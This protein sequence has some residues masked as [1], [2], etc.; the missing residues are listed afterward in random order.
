MSALQR[1]K[2]LGLAGLA[3]VSFALPAVVKRAI[4][5]RQRRLPENAVRCALDAIRA[6]RRDDARRFVEKA[7]S[8]RPTDAPVTPSTLV[9]A[10]TELAEALRRAGLRA[11]ARAAAWKA[12]RFHHQT[13][14]PAEDLA[15]W[16]VLAEDWST[17]DASRF[18]GVLS[19]VSACSDAAARRVAGLVRAE[20]LAAWGRDLEPTAHRARRGRPSFAFENARPVDA[21]LGP[22]P[23]RRVGQNAVVLVGSGAAEMSFSLA[24]DVERLELVAGAD[25][26]FG[27]GA[28]ALVT[29]D[30]GEPF[31]LYVSGTSLVEHPFPVSLSAGAHRIR[32]EYLNDARSGAQDRN[33]FL[34]VLFAGS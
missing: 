2:A 1:S 12:V 33:L 8:F 6:G 28:I 32:V 7:L 34:Y 3:V 11:E 16:V 21:G 26:A 9:P 22:A 23:L 5:A 31:P 18:L 17:H 27:I 24:R 14:P 20:T 10:Y 15:P 29:F 4:D 30:G 25:D 19:I 13:R